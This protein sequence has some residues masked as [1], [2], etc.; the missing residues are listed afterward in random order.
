MKTQVPDVRLRPT[1][2]ASAIALVA[3]VTVLSGCGSAAR[4]ASDHVDAS[5]IR[6]IRMNMSADDVTAI[7]GQPFSIEPVPY[8]PGG[9]V[10]NYS[11]RVPYSWSYPMLWV[12]LTDGRVVEVYA[13]LYEGFD[14]RGVYTLNVD[15]QWESSDFSAIF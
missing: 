12:H 14:D 11:R 6:Q 5:R 4:M 15:R 3:L 2:A 7:L 10:M 13:K 8:R 9:V 1:T